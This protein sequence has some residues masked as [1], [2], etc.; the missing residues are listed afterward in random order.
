MSFFIFFYL[1]FFITFCLIAP[2]NAVWWSKIELI[3]FL[4]LL[5]LVCPAFSS[6]SL[7]SLVLRLR[8]YL[9]VPLANVCCCF[10]ATELKPTEQLRQ[11]SC[12]SNFEKFQC[13]VD[14]LEVDPIEDLKLARAWA[15]TCTHQKLSAG[16]YVCVCVRVVSE[17]SAA[18]FKRAALPDQG[19]K[20]VFELKRAR[21]SAALL[22]FFSSNLVV[23]RWDM[24]EMFSHCG[25]VEVCIS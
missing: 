3:T 5:F 13:D 2:Q 9:D 21:H 6:A 25:V 11:Q 19:R 10:T 8:F 24:W 18:G 23:R 15:F 22:A 4:F 12:R 17:W 14:V 7:S 1:F 16:L 20:T